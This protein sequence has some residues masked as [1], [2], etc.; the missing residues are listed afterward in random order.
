MSDH[1]QKLIQQEANKTQK[2]QQEQDAREV[3]NPIVDLQRLVGN[4]GVQRLIADGQIDAPSQ[5]ATFIQTKM[6]VGAADDAYER[7]ADNVA[8]QV[9]NGPGADVAQREAG[10]DD[11]QMKRMDIQRIEDEDLMQGKRD[12]VQ[13][14]EMPEEE[15]PIQAKGMDIQRMEEEEAQP[16]RMDIQRE[17]MPEEEE[18]LQAKRDVVQRK[19]MEGSFDVGGDVEDQIQSQKGSGQS[20]S[21]EDQSFFGSRF[22]HDFSDVNI[23]TDSASNDLN[24]SIQARAFTTG[25]DVFFREGEYNPGSKS[26]QELIA[27][28][29]THVVQ[30]GGAPVQK[31]EDSES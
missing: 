13:R 10:D 29:L 21:T 30:Q 9:V 23:H 3:S 4:Q 16:K 19:G 11:L 5:P 8:D 2:P 27:H 15:E 12:V 1:V 17:G 26:G 18:P 22:G 20:M 25:S 31:K 24:N 14:E 7:E 6:T 28:E